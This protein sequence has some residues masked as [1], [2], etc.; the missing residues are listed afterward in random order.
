MVLATNPLLESFGCAKTLR[1]NNSSRH[2]SMFGPHFPCSSSIC[3]RVNTW[4][5]CSTHMGSQLAH[6]S[7]ITFWR[8]AEWWA[9][10]R[11]S[12]ISTSSINSPKAHQTSNEVG[13]T[14]HYDLF[15][16]YDQI[17]ETFGLQGPEA[18]A[19]TSVSNCL[20]VQDID[21]VKDY[22]DTIVSGLWTSCDP[23]RTCF[24]QQCKS[25]D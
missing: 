16:W 5:L 19:Y 9:R 25:S 17:T 15:K 8:K 14:K 11:M 12:A 13:Q 18:Y 7:P 2:V 6:R 21:D 24:R 10:L 23:L 20:E 22:H 3:S 4:K 1:N